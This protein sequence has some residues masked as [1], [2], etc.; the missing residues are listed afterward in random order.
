[1]TATQGQ[2]AL[3]VCEVHGD[4]PLKIV[5]YK[6][7]EP[8]SNSYASRKHA[9]QES[10]GRDGAART[11]RL[12]IDAVE[13]SDSAFYACAASNAY[14]KDEKNLQLVVQ[15]PPNPPHDLKA[16]EVKSRHIAISWTEPSDGNSPLLGYLVH[17]RR[18][19]GN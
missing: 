15:G 18:N 2:Q 14:G 11:A 19:N 16:R 9:I 5:W 4:G 3:L 6:E 1:M 17:Y 7:R 12:S 10:E 8:L 13:V